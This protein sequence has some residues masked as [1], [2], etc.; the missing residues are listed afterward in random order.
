MSAIGV[1]YSQKLPKT[2]PK[3]KNN[4]IIQNKLLNLNNLICIIQKNI[5][6]LQRIS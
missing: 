3:Y 2:A 6:P 5:V 1:F 4:A